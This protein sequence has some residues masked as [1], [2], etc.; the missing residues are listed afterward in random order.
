MYCVFFGLNEYTKVDSNLNSQ[1]VVFAD[2]FSGQVG[3]IVK[4]CLQLN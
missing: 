3:R 1:N 4:Y 2:V